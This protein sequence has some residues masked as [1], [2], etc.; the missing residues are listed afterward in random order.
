MERIASSPL[1]RRIKL[2]KELLVAISVFNAISSA[3]VILNISLSLFLYYHYTP[4]GAN[5]KYFYKK[6][7]SIQ[8]SIVSIAK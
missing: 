4:F 6:I 5:V 3:T 8:K 7:T 2:L 1:W